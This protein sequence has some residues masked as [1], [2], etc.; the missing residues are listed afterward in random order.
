MN[1]ELR[2]VGHTNKGAE[3][4]LR[5]MIAHYE[6][7][8]D[9]TLVGNHRVADATQRARLGLKG[10]VYR[11]VDDSS[12]FIP[13]AWLVPGP[14]R[15]ALGV[16][17]P[18]E[19]DVI[20]DGAGFAY[21]DSWGP[22]KAAQSAAYYARVKGRGGRVILLPQS[23]GPFTKPDVAEATQ[24]LV[25]T[26]DLV[27]VRDA[28]AARVLRAVCGDRPSIVQAPDFTPLVHAADVGDVALPARAAAIIPN[29]KMI[30]QTS[31][32]Q[33][34]YEGFIA[35]VIERMRE[36]GLNPFLLPHAHQDQP[37]V[38]RLSR[39]FG[40][41]VAVVHEADALRLKGL[42][43][44]CEVV[45]CSRFHGLV[46]ALCQGVPV[47]ATGWSHKYRHLLE[48]YE[49]G[50]LLLDPREPAEQ[51]SPRIDALL[52]PASLAQWRATLGRRAAWHADEARAMWSRVD[53]LLGG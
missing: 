2:H 49:A 52:A 18:D 42:I 46:S 36:A 34:G 24:A 12:A 4:M 53:A 16:V 41:A 43:G 22:A 35:G 1:I 48:E 47:V 19:I 40:D 15:R 28:T 17:H 32:G 33:D 20:L 45:M 9:V 14:L 3:L 25:D 7:R 10:L 37:L 13:P 29:Q 44:R 51:W 38:D 6:G 26:A 21:G 50:A 30:D 5:A 11:R 31:T 39:R 8:P 27:F 23:F